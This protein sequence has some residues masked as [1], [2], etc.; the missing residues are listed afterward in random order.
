MKH[1]MAL[2]ASCA[3]LAGAP[4]AFA[5]TSSTVVS[6]APNGATTTTTTTVKKDKGGTVSGAAGGA[7]AGAVVAGPVGLVVGAVAGATIGH[8]VAPPKEVKTYVTTQTVA[9]VGY[10]GDIAVGDSLH[11]DIAWRTVPNYPR[12]SWARLN[13]QSVVIDNDTH[14]VVEVY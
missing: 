3:C 7:L 5:E 9:P 13:A 8:S 10:V 11:G 14:K 12:Y 4:S 1:F 6:E 2:A